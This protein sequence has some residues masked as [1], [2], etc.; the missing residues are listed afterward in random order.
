MLWPGRENN[1][2][3]A[4][5]SGDFNTATE[6]FD[7]RLEGREAGAV[8]V[9]GLQCGDG[10]LGDG[11]A[12]GE[13]LLRYALF[14]ADL[15]EPVGSLLGLHPGNMLGNGG[16]VDGTLGAHVTPRGGLRL[17]AHLTPPHSSATHRTC[18]RRSGCSGRTTASICLLCLRR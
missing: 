9:A 12:V 1:L 18:H 13:F 17:G 11:H 16:R 15:A 4:E 3:V 14:F 6:S 5:G 10:G 2:S 7:V 8:E